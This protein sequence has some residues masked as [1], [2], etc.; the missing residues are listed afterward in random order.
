MGA[1]IDRKN[2]NM[3]VSDGRLISLYQKRK[4]LIKYFI[5]NY[6]DSPSFHHGNITQSI[7][8]LDMLDIEKSHSRSA[9]SVLAL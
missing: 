9:S 3:T 8:V 5:L 7:I 4:K 6:S 1:Y 2:K